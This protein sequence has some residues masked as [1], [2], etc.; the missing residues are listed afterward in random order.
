MRDP[1]LYRANASSHLINYKYSGFQP[2][3]I[4]CRPLYCV[5]RYGNT[6]NNFYPFVIFRPLFQKSKAGSHPSSKHFPECLPSIPKGFSS[7]S[8]QP[9]RHSRLAVPI[10]LVSHFSYRKD[11]RVDGQTKAETGTPASLIAANPP[12]MSTRL[13]IPLLFKIEAAIMLL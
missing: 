2:T 12:V 8:L 11:Y 1:Q 6:H 9:C 7:R 4:R 10:L 3:P 5:A 13:W